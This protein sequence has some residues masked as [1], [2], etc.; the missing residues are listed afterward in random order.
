VGRSTAA[1]GIIGGHL[2]VFGG[3]G[4][5]NLALSDMWVLSLVAK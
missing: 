2:F 5:N 1:T 4:N 3:T